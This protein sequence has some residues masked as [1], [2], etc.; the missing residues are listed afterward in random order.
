MLTAVRRGLVARHA[1]QS[2]TVL[3]PATQFHAVR[4]GLASI[5][6]LETLTANDVATRPVKTARSCVAE[7]HHSV[8]QIKHVTRNLH[9]TL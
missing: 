5:S 6:V 7:C 4:R 1:F 3:A 9:A 8:E 2:T